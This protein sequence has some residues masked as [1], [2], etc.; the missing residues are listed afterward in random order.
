MQKH[1]SYITVKGVL[2]VAIGPVGVLAES[3]PV[4]V[5]VERGAR[6]GV[7]VDVTWRSAQHRARRLRRQC[8]PARDAFI[9]HFALFKTT[10]PTH[11]IKIHRKL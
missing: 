9:T 1:G 10:V 8:S 7:R 2:T 5:E 11:S 4:S 6:A 3:G